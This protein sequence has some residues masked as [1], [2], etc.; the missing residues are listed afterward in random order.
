MR[1][2][3][4]R[5]QSASRVVACCVVFLASIVAAACSP[6][7]PGV[8]SPVAAAVDPSFAVLDLSNGSVVA[9]VKSTWRNWE[10]VAVRGG[11][12]VPGYVATPIELDQCDGKAWQQFEFTTAGDIRVGASTCLDASGA[13]GQRGDPVVTWPWLRRPL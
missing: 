13:T 2:L 4:G 11:V 5:P 7:S 9:T 10:C 12:V 3:A 6:D 8:V 1:P